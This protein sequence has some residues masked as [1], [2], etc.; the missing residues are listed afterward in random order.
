MRLAA[1]LLLALASPAVAD[2]VDDV[3]DVDDELEQLRREAA[4][5]RAQVSTL[6]ALRRFVSADVDL[7]AFVAG[8]DGS[9]IRYDVGHMLFPEYRMTV[10]SAWVFL[11]DPL[12]TAINARGEPAD[13]GPSRSLGPDRIDSGGAPTALVSSLGLNVAK[14]VLPELSLRARVE[15]MPRAGEDD[16]DVA[17]ARIEYRPARVPG[18]S[19]TAGRIDSVLGVEYRKQDAPDRLTVTPSL[20][21]RYTCGRPAGVQARLRRGSSTAAVSVT[22][23]D[24]FQDLFEP[25]RVRSSGAPFVSARIGQTLPIAGGTELG[26]SG[27][28][29]PQ[30]AAVTPDAPQWHLGVD[31]QIHN[32]R[33]VEVQAEYVMGRLPGAEGD[34]WAKC[35]AAPCLRYRAA[36]VLAGWRATNWAMPY[37][38]ADIRDALHL[39]GPEFVYVSQVGRATIGARL[40]LQDRALLKFEYTWNRELGRLPQFNN[41]V[42]TTSIV[43]TTD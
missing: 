12:S 31:L 16:L 27:A 35:D 19:V 37:V 20:A 38:R 26:M 28:V 8:G 22:A 34:A 30:A 10:P 32:L 6:M 29:G 5:D 15:L 25:E 3:D 18:L 40:D 24:S 11:G 13:T 41:D 9:G 23:T 36:Y 7:G 4:Q 43:L 42:F 2:D 33:H 17:I 39:F 1:C 14:D 21:C